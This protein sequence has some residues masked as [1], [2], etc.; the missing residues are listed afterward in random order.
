MN[1]KTSRGIPEGFPESELHFGNELELAEHERKKM[2]MEKKKAESSV[3][4]S[5]SGRE[6][7]V[8]KSMEV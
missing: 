4:T 2:M 7:N 8:F 1:L 3:G 5:R 6:K